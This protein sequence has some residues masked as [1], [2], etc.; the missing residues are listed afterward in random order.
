MEQLKELNIT[1]TRPILDSKL[2]GLLRGVLPEPLKDGLRKILHGEKAYY[3]LDKPYF[4]EVGGVSVKF[5]IQ[6]HS[7]WWRIVS[8]S[9]N[10]VVES[11]LEVVGDGSVVADI[12]S[13]QGLFALPATKKGAR[14]F[15]IDPDPFMVEALKRNIKLNPETEENI[16]IA[17][18]ALGDTFQT[19]T[20]RIDPNRRYAGSAR[21]S[22]GGLTQ[23]IQVQQTTYDQYFESKNVWPDVVKIDVEGAEDSVFDGMKNTLVSNHCPKH[24]FLELHLRYLPKFGT[25]SEVVLEKMSNAGYK[26]VGQPQQR[27]GEVHLHFAK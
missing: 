20:F 18:V 14:V 16:T 17:S 9:E 6:T 19:V 5:N 27:G 8:G 22:I 2:A 25:T 13:A 3:P 21:N 11:L 1:P 24:I 23:E 12:G 7:D 10:P 4:L 26:V 15:A